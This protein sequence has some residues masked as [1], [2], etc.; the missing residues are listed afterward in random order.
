M[1]GIAADLVGELLKTLWSRT[2]LRGGTVAQVGV[3]RVEGVLVMV[4]G[5]GHEAEPHHCFGREEGGW[6]ILKASEHLW[7]PPLFHL[8][9]YVPKSGAV[10]FHMSV[11]LAR[12]E[13][14]EGGV[15]GV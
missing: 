13:K 4:M 3:I 1:R 7:E 2:N 5:G 8:T 10:H 6:H 11:P 12:W 9:I 14:G 15:A